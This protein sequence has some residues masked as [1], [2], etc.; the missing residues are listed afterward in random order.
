MEILIIIMLIIL[1]I[2]LLFVEFMLIPG[3][4]IAGVGSLLSFAGAVLFAWKTMGSAGGIITLVVE[5]II[6]PT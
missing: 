6:V 4:S 3:V 5:L 1:G 2:V